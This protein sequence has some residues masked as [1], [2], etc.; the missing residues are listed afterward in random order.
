MFAL[1]T[2]VPYYT[3]QSLPEDKSIDFMISPR[4]GEVFKS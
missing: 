2:I 1:E 4:F 3:Y